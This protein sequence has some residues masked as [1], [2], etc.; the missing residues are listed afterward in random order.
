M[1]PVET[2]RMLE[3]V[4]EVY[5][6]ALRENPQAAECVR[7]LGITDQRVLDHFRAGYSD[8]TLTKMLPATGE[9]PDTLRAL[10]LLG[11]AGDE[12]LKGALVVPV[13]GSHGEINGFCGVKAGSGG[14]LV[15]L[16]LPEPVPGLVRGTLVKDAPR[17]FVANRV[18][19]G[20]ALWVAG[21]TNVAM[22]LSVPAS[23]D[24]LEQ[25]IRELG[26][27]EVCLCF[28][29]AEPGKA[30]LPK[31]EGVSITAVPWPA[32]I[33]GAREFFAVN[34]PPEFEK[35]L[36]ES[37]S[38]TSAQP[39]PI[40]A[41]AIRE[42]VDG[43]DACFDER[44]YQLRV[45]LQPGPN[46]LRA[47]IRALGEA[48][49]FAVETIDFYSARSRRGLV[50]E[51][52]RLFGHP[53]DVIESDMSRLT[54]AAE[55]YVKRHTTGVRTA[56]PEMRGDER[57]AGLKLGRSPDLVGE[58]V[59]DM[60]ALGMV[61]E[62]TNKLLAYLVMTSRRLSEPLALLIVSGSGAGKSHLQD[63][64]LALCPEEDLIRLTSLT[65]QALYYR[66]EDSL[67]H[68]VL[69][70]EEQ[71]GAKGAGYAIRNL[72]SAHKLVIET[73]AKNA[74]TGKLEAQLYTVH[75]PTAVF[76]TTTNPSTDAETRSRFIVVSVDESPEQTRAILRRQREA[77]TLEGLHRR[78]SR[79]AILQRHHAFQRLPRALSVV[80]PFEPLLS[81][82]DEHLL[83]RRDHPKYLQLV[84]TLAFLHQLQ[85]PLRHDPDLGEYIEVTLDDV[86]IANQLA[87]QVFG[88]SLSDL[89]RPAHDL[90]ALMDS[91][92]RDRPKGAMETDTFTRR[93]LREAIHWGDTRLRTHLRELVSLEHVVALSG[94]FGTT[95]RYRRVPHS[96]N[97][98]GRFLAGLKSVEQ[99]RHEAD[100]VGILAGL[101]PASQAKTCEVLA[102][103]KPS[104]TSPYHDRDGTSQPP[105]GEGVLVRRND[106]TKP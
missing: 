33:S 34:S 4:A 89:S 14:D 47:T 50:A 28:S 37:M 19:D 29:N 3:R 104:L 6:R 52:A 60:T 65:D 20:F 7:T 69:A 97:G 62:E 32:G 11:Q 57:A 58:I 10:G 88:N 81:Y 72:L 84:L 27:H 43:L 75:G 67:R 44:C 100:L 26:P 64:A 18:L 23:V 91:F 36:P 70:L 85:R 63:T 74:M 5:A 24:A 13:M 98:N 56:A 77:H 35:L 25:L 68:K 93:E 106:C 30:V 66:G 103:I 71:A 31:P 51:A 38:K 86:A 17:L 82:P 21:F 42:T 8:G 54:G 49:R 48:G 59:R 55:A 45:I 95:Y 79:E 16:V 12:A 96:A 53:L 105:R 92:L 46:R 61:G 101:A 90:L 73:T 9:L 15:E 39:T 80:N 40:D 102:A 2:V 1:K 41:S 83:V 94:R 87:H 78:Q 22:V 99:I 76:Q